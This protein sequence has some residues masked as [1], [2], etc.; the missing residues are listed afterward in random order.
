LENDENE[1]KLNGENKFEYLL[2]DVQTTTLRN[3]MLSSNQPDT[4]LSFE[5]TKANNSNFSSKNNEEIKP[6]TSK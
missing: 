5:L 4:T 1:F 3:S 6:L 2:N